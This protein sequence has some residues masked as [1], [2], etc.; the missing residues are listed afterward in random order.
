MVEQ[1]KVA[2][3]PVSAFY[4]EDHVKTVIR[5]CFAKTYDKLDGAVERIAAHIKRG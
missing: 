5:F 3:I 2:A 4:S 1:A